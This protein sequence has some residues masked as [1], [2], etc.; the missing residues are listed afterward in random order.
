[1]LSEYCQYKMAFI[2]R[3]RHSGCQQK[4]RDRCCRALHCSMLLSLVRQMFIL[5]TII[6]HCGLLSSVSCLLSVLCCLMLIQQRFSKS[7]QRWPQTNQTDLDVVGY[8]LKRCLFSSV[9]CILSV[10]CCLVSALV[11]SD[12]D[13]TEVFEGSSAVA[14]TTKTYIAR[15]YS[16]LLWAVFCLLFSV[17][18]L[19][20]CCLVLIQNA[21]QRGPAD[22]PDRF[23][24]SVDRQCSRE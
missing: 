22:K 8:S 11:L 24:S 3:L 4:G 18:F 14:M 16:I 1:M 9:S 6:K 19:R 17:L 13:S 2:Q 7:P 5:S 15:D 10:V 21:P 23:V 20:L 12:V